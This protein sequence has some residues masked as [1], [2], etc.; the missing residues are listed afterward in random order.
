MTN[1]P[2]PTPVQPEIRTRRL[3]ITDDT[4]SPRIVGEVIGGAAEVRVGLP[5]EGSRNAYVLLYAVPRDG[6]GLGPALGVQLWANGDA[7]SEMSL[8]WDDGRWTANLR[9]LPDPS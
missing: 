1:E 8:S 7:Y 5:G 6:T 9:T 2:S 3:I 4:G